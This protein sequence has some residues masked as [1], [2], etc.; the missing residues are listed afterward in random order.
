MLPLLGESSTFKVRRI[1][2]FRLN[3]NGR[4]S[5]QS[6]LSV[7]AKSFAFARNETST[8]AV[9][10][11]CLFCVLL[12]F[13]PELLLLPYDLYL[14]VFQHDLEDLKE[15]DCNLLHSPDS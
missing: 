4:I 14:T 2:V 6:T 10:F 11:V 5:N 8:Q 1:F 7:T 15:T 3:L 9:D 13:F 12:L